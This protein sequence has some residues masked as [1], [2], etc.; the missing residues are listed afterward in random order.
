LI[1]KLFDFSQHLWVIRAPSAF[2]YSDLTEKSLSPMS[3]FFNTRDK[4]S[5]CRVEFAHTIP[6]DLLSPIPE[7]LSNL[8]LGLSDRTN[9]NHRQCTF[10]STG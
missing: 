9:I 4:V 1:S 6:I 8:I 5:P 3:S 2:L 7:T 10:Q